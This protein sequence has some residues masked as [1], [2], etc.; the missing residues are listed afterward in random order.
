MLHSDKMK[1][2]IKKLILFIIMPFVGFLESFK[3]PWSSASRKIMFLWFV[4]F[5]M[6][7][8]PINKHADS[9]RY[10]E[11]F[12]TESVATDAY[13]HEQIK[14]YF[15]NVQSTTTRDIYV[16][17]MTYIVSRVTNN[18][19]VFYMA[20]AFVFAFFYV[21]SMKFIIP[22]PHKRYEQFVIPILFCLFCLSN[23]I[24][25][26]NG[27]RFWTAA[28]IA[29]FIVFQIIV[30]KKYIYLLLA[31]VTILVHASFIIFV[32][33]LGLYLVVGQLDGM[34]RAI[35]YLSLIFAVISFSP[36]I[37]VS[38][39]IQLPVFLL[40]EIDTYASEEAISNKQFN[41]QNL[42]IYAQIFNILP[43][44]LINVISLVLLTVSKKNFIER[45]NKNVFRFMIVLLAFANFTF[46]IPSVGVRFFRMVFP[47]IIFLLIKQ[48]II[49]SKYKS[50]IYLIPFAFLLDIVSWFRN[51]S[52]VT[53]I[54]DY[55][56]PLPLLLIKYLG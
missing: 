44:I 12:K 39:R 43:R 35:Y 10:V 52:E 48:P 31:P 18:Y 8:T 4:V 47:F 5:G 14:E 41:F 2:L 32:I 6:C 29:V 27:V 19:H 15:E 13:F 16:V 21:K 17:V 34:W 20:L 1:E 49:A 51:M 37:D 40:N 54:I 22:L 46:I 33:L 23:P 9:W 55:I 24:Y 3:R 7:F 42:P 30:N 50:L 56:A 45:E 38:S 26:I 28:W 25:N 53:S 36:N 11:E